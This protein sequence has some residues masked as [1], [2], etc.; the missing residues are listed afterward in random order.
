MKLRDYPPEI[1]NNGKFSL[2]NIQIEVDGEGRHTGKFRK[3]TRPA[4]VTSPPGNWPAHRSDYI[5]EFDGHGI[6]V[7]AEDRTGEKMMSE[8]MDW[9]LVCSAWSRSCVR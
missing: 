4:G 2:D 5:H 7:D 3:L 9:S 8:H 6:G 1:V